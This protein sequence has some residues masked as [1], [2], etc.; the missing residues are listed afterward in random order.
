MNYEETFFF[1]LCMIQVLSISSGDNESPPYIGS[2]LETKTVGDKKVLESH[3]SS[4]TDS[5]S[6]SHENLECRICLS[7]KIDVIFYKCG[8]M[9]CCEN[10]ALKVNRSCPVCRTLVDEIVKIF[11]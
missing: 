5:S 10:C 6:V 9:F 2:L 8:L 11:L 3:V 4:V 7:N 1:T